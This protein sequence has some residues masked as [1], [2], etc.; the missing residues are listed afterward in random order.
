MEIEEGRIDKEDRR[1]VDLT[2]LRDILVISRVRLNT[3]QRYVCV[4]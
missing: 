3:A 4:F 1:T 2:H